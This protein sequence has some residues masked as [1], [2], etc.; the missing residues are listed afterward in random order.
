MFVKSSAGGVSVNGLGLLEKMLGKHFTAG[1]MMACKI[2]PM[3]IYNGST[4]GA[5]RVVQGVLANSLSL[6][7]AKLSL[8]ALEK[9]LSMALEEL[10]IVQLFDSDG[11]GK[12]AIYRGGSHLRIVL[13]GDHQDLNW[14]YVGDNVASDVQSF[15]EP[16]A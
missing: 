3:E 7:Y 5:V 10:G 11:L 1:E 8:A 2:Y 4:A 13:D 16:V 9:Q 12:V 6:D 15:L 14:L